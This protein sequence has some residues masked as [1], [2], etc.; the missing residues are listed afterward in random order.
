MSGLRRE[1]HFSWNTFDQVKRLSFLMIGFTAILTWNHPHAA[2]KYSQFQDPE[3]NP[4]VDYL[5]L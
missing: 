3:T 5:Y 2:P 1:V 4:S